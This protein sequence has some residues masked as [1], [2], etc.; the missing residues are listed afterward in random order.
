MTNLLCNL[1]T[2]KRSFV[3]FV[4]SGGAIIIEGHDYVEQPDNCLQCRR[5]G[6]V[7]L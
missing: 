5:C 2:I 3:S 1:I 4:R 6:E 7:S